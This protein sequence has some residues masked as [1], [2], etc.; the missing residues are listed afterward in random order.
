MRKAIPQI[1]GTIL[2]LAFEL[3]VAAGW[4]SNVAPWFL[5]ALWI[6]PA[7]L[8]LY[9][10]T[11]HEKVRKH[12]LIK[13]L[14]DYPKMSFGLFVLIGGLAGASA[15]AG[16]W[17]LLRRPSAANPVEA[18][19]TVKTKEP[20]IE[21]SY[22]LNL[23]GLPIA[24]DPYSS[25]VLIRVRQDRTVNAGT[26]INDKAVRLAWPTSETITPPEQT[27][28]IQLSNHGDVGVFNVSYSLKLSIGSK[29]GPEGIV[30]V[31]VNLPLIDLP[32]GG[33]PISFYIV[34][35][36]SFPVLIELSDT[37]LLDVQG[38]KV[39]RVVK[40]QPRDITFFDK[41]PILEMSWHK[42]SGDK[43]LTPDLWKT[44]KGKKSS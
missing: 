1:A 30:A 34:N 22:N 26:I 19:P 38:E 20:I 40:V 32:M 2:T 39:R 16:A 25:I 9:Y 43:M 6:L 23:I 35:Q 3:S 29:G 14:Y 13:V 10:L 44:R 42:W 31:D 27:G 15:G 33:R 8:W 24:I 7:L 4:F 28:Q 18:E 36:S 12:R 5:I 21:P 11:T 17:G 41:A 37:V